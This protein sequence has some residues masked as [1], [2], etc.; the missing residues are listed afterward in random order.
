MY[1]NSNSIN[2]DE[3]GII[4]PVLNQQELVE[5]LKN[6]LSK[7]IKDTSDVLDS[8]IITLDQSIMDENIRNESKTLIKELRKDFSETL[9]T[10]YKDSS[11]SVA[12][13]QNKYHTIRHSEEE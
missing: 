10:T 2:E 9:N 6:S 5:D 12:N 3:P 7:T 8:I 11:S 13:E 1:E 4:N